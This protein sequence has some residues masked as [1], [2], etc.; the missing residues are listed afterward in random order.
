MKMLFTFLLS[1]QN[2]TEKESEEETKLK[3]F[4]TPTRWWVPKDRERKK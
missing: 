1:E 2:E 4:H 3:Y